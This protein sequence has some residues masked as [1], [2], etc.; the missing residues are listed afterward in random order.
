MAVEKRL[1]RRQI[2]AHAEHARGREH[3]VERRLAVAVNELVDALGRQ[4][5]ELE[6]VGE[7]VGLELDLLGHARAVGHVDP[8]GQSVAIEGNR[9]VVR[10]QR[11]GPLNRPLQFRRGVSGK[12]GQRRQSGREPGVERD[13]FGERPGEQ[14]PGDVGV[15]PQ[16]GGER[17]VDRGRLLEGVGHRADGQLRLVACLAEARRPRHAHGGVAGIG[18]L[19]SHL[20]LHAR[21]GAGREL[22]RGR[23]VEC[24]GIPR[25][26]L[27]HRG[28][29]GSVD[30]G[31]EIGERRV[32]SGGGL[33]HGDG[34]GGRTIDEVH[35]R[36]RAEPPGRRSSCSEVRH[37]FARQH[38]RR[39]L[40]RRAE[41][42]D[43]AAAA[44]E[45]KVGRQIHRRATGDTVGHDPCGLE[46]EA[47]VVE[48]I[49]ERR[50]VE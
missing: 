38:D 43:P 19:G 39:R 8:V 16:V 14:R 12:R 15:I 28:D 31:E 6:V 5:A 29:A 4:T 48:E 47:K 23:G 44:G 2:D 42:R 27:P 11:H 33:R 20:R 32:V 13:V 21:A 9:K 25:A 37:E 17:G 1:H 10:R 45:R 26:D 18:Q 22:Q 30:V 34:V 50:V 49:R 3:E 24:L 36:V 40:V 35:R 41:H 7:Q 46:G